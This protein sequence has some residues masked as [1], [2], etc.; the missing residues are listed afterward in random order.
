[1]ID[2]LPSNP[3][4]NCNTTENASILDNASFVGGSGN[5]GSTPDCMIVIF[6]LPAP[7]DVQA[8]ISNL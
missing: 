5:T 8:V 3:G 6:G 2:E 1:V 7:T 4:V